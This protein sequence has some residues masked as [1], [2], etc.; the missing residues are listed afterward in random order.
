M[1]P[2]EQVLSSSPLPA[3]PDPGPKSGDEILPANDLRSEAKNNLAASAP[4]NDDKLRQNPLPVNSPTVRRPHDPTKHELRA[5]RS[6]GGRPRKGTHRLLCELAI[7]TSI[8]KAAKRAGVSVR[9][10][11]RRYADREFIWQMLTLRKQIRGQAIGRISVVMTDAVETLKKA[12]TTEMPMS[13]IL[14]ARWL[15]KFGQEFGVLGEDFVKQEI[16]VEEAQR[17][18]KEM[19][20]MSNQTE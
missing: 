12:L 20:G 14:A 1:M 2:N 17:I 8:R 11:Q 10:A 9:T 6:I 15:V 3:T 4:E 18:V 7:G 16:M 5:L 19:T 13:R